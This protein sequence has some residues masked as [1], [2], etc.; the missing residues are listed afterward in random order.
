MSSNQQLPTQP[1]PDWQI[2]TT[3]NTEKPQTYNISDLTKMPLTTITVKSENATYRGVSLI[4]FANKT[5]AQWDTGTLTITAKSGQTS[6]INIYQA[7]NSTVYPYN[8]PHN[9]IILAFIKNDQWL[10]SQ[11]GGPLKLIAPSFDV[12]YQIEQVIQIDSQ[13]WIVSVTGNIANPI[14]ITG[15]NLT[16]FQSQ[17]IT[18]EFRP[19]GDP[20][21]T[22][23]W[24]GITLIDLINIAQI[25]NRAAQ[26]S[27]IGIDNYTKTFTLEQLQA[28]KMMMLG[29][30]E[31]GEPLP[32]NEG[33]PFRLFIP[34]NTYKWGQYWVKYVTEIKVS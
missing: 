5:G 16:V 7:W 29:Y 20:T 28:E 26:V 21:R 18:G 25:T 10:T 27:V 24:T 15:K 1:S 30:Q 6:S 8:H 4:D 31:N 22:S 2:K 9:S 23:D 32:I 11:E 3:G 12:S 19:G 14:S 13:P 34:T 17:T 33:G